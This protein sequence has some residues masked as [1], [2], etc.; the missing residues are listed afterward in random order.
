MRDSCQYLGKGHSLHVDKRY[1]SI[2]NLDTAGGG[3]L[4]PGVQL[5]E[6]TLIEP[7]GRGGMGQVWKATDGKR[8]VAVKVLPAEFRGNSAAV[9]QIDEAF[10][11]VHALTHQHICK[12]LGLFNDVR[13]GPY[14]V[15]DFVSGITLTRYQRTFP[16]RRVPFPQAMD[17]LRRV[18]QALDYAHQKT[19]RSEGRELHGVL[20]RDVKPDNILL[21]FDANQKLEEVWLIDFGLAAE[22]RNSMTKHTNK[23]ADTRGTRPYMAPEQCRGKR[24]QWDGRTDQY[25]LAVVAYELLAGHL[26]FDG[27]DEFS[28]TYSILN[29]PPDPILDLPDAAWSALRQGLAKEKE[30]RHATCAA[31]IDAITTRSTTGQ[32]T[33]SPPA[34]HR[35]DL[36]VSPF[37]TAA[38]SKAQQAWAKYLGLDVERTNSLGMKF[39]LIPPGEF[40]M[41]SSPQEIEQICQIDKSFNKDLGQREQPPHLVRVT[42]PIWLGQNLVTRGNFRAFVRATGCKTEGERDGKG[43]YGL[44][45]TEWKQDRSFTWLSPGFEQTEEHPV[46]VVSWNDAMAFLDWLSKEHKMGADYRLPTEAEWEF[47]CRAGTTTIYPNGNDPER[48]V[49][50]GNTA[51]GTFKTMYPKFHSIAS[52]DGYVHTS[53]VGKFAANPWGVYDM[54][55]NVWEWCADRYGENYYGQSP[56]EDPVGPESGSYRV[57]RGGSWSFSAGDCRSA[58][59]RR[60]VPSRLGSRLGFRPCLSSD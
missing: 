2:G 12:T 35:P 1:N 30:T 17:I 13:N 19:I 24:Q 37:D 50:I 9:A 34:G 3:D 8:D 44:I 46:C 26:P 45:G 18:A 43:G 4:Q 27:D 7:V 40:L 56:V 23:S 47:A 15:M 16:D 60:S 42:R 33:A 10:R 41:G 57:Y 14:L 48:L 51:D 49:E 55:G 22:I 39:R 21:V 31:L 6:Y 54:I 38:A 52:Q 11:V 53:P 36:L 5:G 25:A 20:H 29:E 58:C 32:P 28:I 59:R